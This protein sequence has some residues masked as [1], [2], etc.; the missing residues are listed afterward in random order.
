MLVAV[1]AFIAWLFSAGTIVNFISEP[2][3]IGFK[4]GVA[5]FLAS[6]Q[7]PKLCGLKGS[8][9]DFWERSDH[10]LRHLPDTNLPSLVIGMISLGVLVSGKV[11]LKNKPV[12]IVVVLGG[13]LAASIMNLSAGALSSWVKCRKDF[14]RSVCR[15]FVWRISTKCFHCPSH[16][17]C[18]ARLR[19]RRSAG[20]SAR[21]M[22]DV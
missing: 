3:M 16:A 19:R 7:L 2:V 6:T 22:V 13:I 17:F 18:S 10:F 12:A 5:L 9:G 1:I 20:C 11:L 14:R 4:C 21:N 15:T 8:H